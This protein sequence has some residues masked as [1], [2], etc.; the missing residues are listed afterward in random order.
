VEIVR[1]YVGAFDA[2]TLQGL[3]EALDRAHAAG[4][5]LLPLT[6]C[7]DGGDL[8][9]A[10][11]MVDVLRASPIPV[12][13]IA[14]G[15]A[16]SSGALLLACGAPGQRY[17]APLATVMVHEASTYPG[18]A[19]KPHEAQLDAADLVRMNKLMCGALDTATRRRPGTWAR[20]LADTKADLVL[21]A[22]EAVANRLAD[23]VGV[24]LPRLTL[25][26]GP[27][28]PAPRA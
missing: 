11:A 16:Q 18:G 15:Q 6:I 12:A 24:P 8:H 7:S 21:S 10:F 9:V 1:A 2:E 20:R 13:T 14:V 19:L 17:V 23:H 4:Q 3:I 27:E 25:T 26:L 22:H 28:G 5:G